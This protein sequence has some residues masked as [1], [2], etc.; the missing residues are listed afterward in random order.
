MY[1]ATGLVE[2]VLDPDL[3]RKPALGAEA[4]VD[5]ARGALDRAQVLGVLGNVLARRVEEREHPYAA[6]QLGMVLQ[7]QLVGAEAAHDVLG[8]ISAVDPD[9]QELRA[10]GLELRLL[11]AH[12]LALRKVGELRRVDGDGTRVDGEVRPSYV[13]RP[14][15][16]SL[17][18][19]STSSQQRRKFRH[20]RSVWKL[21]RSLASIPSCTA[22]RML[23]GSTRQ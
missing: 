5:H 10:L 12:A 13:T 16:K 1:A 18:A 11:F 22:R 2:V 6:V 8:R 15:L 17:F 19:P 14:A 4:V 3:E 23:S 20:Q 7:E 21:T 9:D